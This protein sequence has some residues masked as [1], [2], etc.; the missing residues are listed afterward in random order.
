MLTFIWQNWICATGL[1]ED[2][3]K[4]LCALK[5]QQEKGP[6]PVEKG[7]LEMELCA[8]VCCPRRPHKEP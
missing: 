5:S 3:Q 4:M 6:V 2:V 1:M 8:W 7:I